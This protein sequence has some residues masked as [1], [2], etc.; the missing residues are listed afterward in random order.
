MTHFSALAWAACALLLLAG[1]AAPEPPRVVAMA[2]EPP[3]PALPAECR[4]PDPGWEPLPKDRDVTVSE[5]A[6]NYRT[7]KTRYRALTGR[8]AVCRAALDTY[9][10]EKPGPK[11]PAKKR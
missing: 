11:S 1:C 6:R 2:M 5:A 8:R 4:A 9:Y 10:P 3:R 7:N